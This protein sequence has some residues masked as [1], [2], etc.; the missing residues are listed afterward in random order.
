MVTS[1]LLAIPNSHLQD[2]GRAKRLEELRKQEE[3]AEAARQKEKE[4]GGEK[5]Q[6]RSGEGDEPAHNGQTAVGKDQ[7][8][9]RDAEINMSVTE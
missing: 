9:D 2:A 7:A 8:A 1:E 5:A 4:K 3:E 6:E